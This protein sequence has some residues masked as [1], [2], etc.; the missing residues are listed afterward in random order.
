MALVVF[1][2]PQ[3]SKM[4]ILQLIQNKFILNLHNFQEQDK[5]FC[6]HYNFQYKTN[7]K[8]NGYKKNKKISNFINFL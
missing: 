2:L 7:K 1:S 6:H 3:L 4:G 8:A 5:Y